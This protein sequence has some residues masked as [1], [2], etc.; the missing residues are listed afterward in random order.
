MKN[1]FGNTFAGMHLC[2]YLYLYLY[3]WCGVVW[4]GVVWC[5]VV[6]CGVVW[7]GVVWCGQALPVTRECPNACQAPT[8][9][10]L[11]RGNL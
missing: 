9:A 4:C 6:W 7:C 2:F 5:G 3:L 8:I 11:L 10:T 1:E